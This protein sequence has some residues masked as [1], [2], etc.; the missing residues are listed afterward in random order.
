MDLSNGNILV[1]DDDLL[2]RIK[3]STNLEAAGY[4]VTLAT[5]GL[6]GLESMRAH[7]FDTVLLDLMM[8]VMDGFEVLEHVQSDVSLQHTPIIVIS[9]EDDLDSVVRCIEMGAADHL[10]KPFN[11]VILRARI[12]ACVNKK[13]SHDRETKLFAEL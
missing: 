8:P 5:N 10:P 1:V 12:N 4:K 9:A 2:N 6:E 11:P 7:A 13:R 3:L